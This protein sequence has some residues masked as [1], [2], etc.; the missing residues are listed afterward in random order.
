MYE[1]LGMRDEDGWFEGLGVLEMRD[2]G[3]ADDARDLGMR[4]EGLT[5]WLEGFR[6]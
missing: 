5:D 6:D 3:L 2:E 4:D 1:G